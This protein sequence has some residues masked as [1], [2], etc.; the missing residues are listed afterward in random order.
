MEIF[1]KNPL[2]SPI[3]I[4]EKYY[5]ISGKVYVDINIYCNILSDLVGM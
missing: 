5:F 2:N 1:F 4:K 3:K